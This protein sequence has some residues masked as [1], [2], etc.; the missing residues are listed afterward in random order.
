MTEQ[1]NRDE[2]NR[3]LGSLVADNASA[4]ISREELRRSVEGMGADIK[5]LL[6]LPSRMGALEVQ[7]ATNH[8]TNVA[9][10]ATLDKDVTELKNWRSTR[11]GWHEGVRW[12]T[13]FM[14]ALLGA[15]VALLRFKWP[16]W[17]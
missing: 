8:A 14:A 17:G 4:K 9:R 16:P 5:L 12:M 6:Q 10:L 13:H 3:L 15:S 7:T 11:E 2:T 1:E